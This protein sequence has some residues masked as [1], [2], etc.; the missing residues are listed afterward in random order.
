MF[1]KGWELAAFAKTNQFNKEKNLGVVETQALFLP[2]LDLIVGV[3]GL[4][5]LLYGG[6]LALIGEITLGRF[7]AFNQYIAMLVW[8]MMAAGECITS[9]SQGLASMKRIQKIFDEQPEIVDEESVQPV[10]RLEG[11]IE[12]SHLTF[13][14]PGH[15]KKRLFL[16]MLLFLLRK[17][18]LWQSLDVPE[19]ERQP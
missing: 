5:T 9:L 10:E 7:V 1:R 13:S 19:A 17:E 18:L 6:Y 4:L 2:L 11:N 14:Y 3:S 15:E 8:P 16:K 12:I